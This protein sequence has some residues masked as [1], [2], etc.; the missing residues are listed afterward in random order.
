MKQAILQLHN[1]TL[2]KEKIK[3]LGI[4]FSSSFYPVKIIKD[5]KVYLLTD[6]STYRIA[7]TIPLHAIGEDI[8]ILEKLG[9]YNLAPKIYKTDVFTDEAGNDMSYVEMERLD[10]TIYDLLKTELSQKD[11]D[12][13]LR[14]INQ[15]LIMLHKMKLSHGDFHWEN[16]GIVY[17]ENK[18]CIFLK[19]F[20]FEF[21]S[22]KND[23]RREVAQLI[24]TV[25]KKYTPL[26][27]ES[28]RSYIKKKL[29]SYY[30]KNFGDYNDIDKE[31]KK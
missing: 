15:L 27:A 5:K 12:L 21:A 17:N 19:M 23:F 13:I 28:N 25:D 8:E 6:K 4:P 16:I 20:D 14:L 24:R 26:I 2:P 31:Y 18:D 11:L 29:E 10:G 9:K 30:K 7:K 22:H 1:T 3:V